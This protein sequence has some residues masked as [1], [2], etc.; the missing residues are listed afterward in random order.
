MTA[1]LNQ[2]DRCYSIKRTDNTALPLNTA[3]EGL[4]LRLKR[5][6]KSLTPL[7]IPGALDSQA[8]STRI[9][10]QGYPDTP[11]ERASAQREG[12]RPHCFHQS[13]ANVVFESEMIPWCTHSSASSNFAVKHSRCSPTSS[14]AP[15]CTRSFAP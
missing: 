11:P 15:T 4:I 8:D 9:E 1:N 14:F 7:R 2:F 5:T 10:Q 12:N 13:S 3:T 6:R